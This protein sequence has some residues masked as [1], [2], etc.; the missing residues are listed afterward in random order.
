MVKMPELVVDNDD[1]A[2]IQ[3]TGA[4]S[5]H[6]KG[7]YGKSML[8]DSS[9]GKA[10]ASIR[11]LPRTDSIRRIPG[12]YLYSQAERHCFGYPYP[13]VRWNQQQKHRYQ[14]RG[15]NGGRTNLRRMDQPGNAQT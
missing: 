14:S 7:A 6:K 3:Q 10:P 12:V 9:K 13:F 4:W 2:H 11:F 5:H 15:Y 8:I 1:T